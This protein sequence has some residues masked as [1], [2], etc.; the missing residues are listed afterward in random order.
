VQHRRI[1][2]LDR[3]LN[4]LIEMTEDEDKV[5]LPDVK[6]I[7]NG[8]NAERVDLVNFNAPLFTLIDKYKASIAAEMGERV[9]KT[10]LTGKDGGPVRVV[11]VDYS[12]FTDEELADIERLAQKAIDGNS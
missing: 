9:K 3:I 10:E 7:G 1:Q 12:R 4:K 2:S 5:W 6:A 11:P 8:P